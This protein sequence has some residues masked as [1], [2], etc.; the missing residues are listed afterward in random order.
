[1]GNHIVVTGEDFQRKYLIPATMKPKFKKWREE[2]GNGEHE[3]DHQ[4]RMQ[5]YLVNSDNSIA[6]IVAELQDFR[7]KAK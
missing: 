6:L 4:A 7:K 5:K 2:F 3:D 1:L